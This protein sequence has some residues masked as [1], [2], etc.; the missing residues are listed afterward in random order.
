[1][2]HSLY[3]KWLSNAEF[4]WNHGKSPVPS[5]S[6]NHSVRRKSMMDYENQSYMDHSAVGKSECPKCPVIY[7]IAFTIFFL[8]TIPD[9]ERN[10]TQRS[11]ISHIMRGVSCANAPF[12]HLFILY[13]L[14][15]VPNNSF[16]YFEN[17]F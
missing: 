9:L 4:E 17:L 13:R 6:I 2:N 11:L 7:T 12:V 8:R 16:C 3:L 15:F 14:T 1:M 10:F 5:W